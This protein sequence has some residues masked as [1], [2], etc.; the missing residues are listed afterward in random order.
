M[1][2]SCYFMDLPEKRSFVSLASSFIRSLLD[3][4]NVDDFMDI[5][6]DGP[7]PLHLDHVLMK[8]EKKKSPAFCRLPLIITYFWSINRFSDG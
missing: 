2:I 4:M 6:L 8:N 5:Y 3:T 7:G 1:L